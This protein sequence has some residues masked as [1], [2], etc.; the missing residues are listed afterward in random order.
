MTKNENIEDYKEVTEAEKMALEK[1]DAEW[2]EPPRS[3]VD[4]WNQACGVW[5]KYNDATGYFELNGLT[6]ISYR[7]ALDIYEFTQITS[8]NGYGRLGGIND[9]S[10]LNIRTNLPRVVSSHGNGNENE[11][12][13]FF[14]YYNESIEVLNIN[15]LFP[16]YSDERISPSSTTLKFICRCGKLQKVLGGISLFHSGENKEVKFIS[17]CQNLEYVEF[18]N[19]RNG[20]ILHL[21]TLPKLSYETFDYMIKNLWNVAVERPATCYVHE[22]I[23]KRFCDENDEQW[24]KLNQT[25]IS[26][27]LIFATQ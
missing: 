10:V 13:N 20:Q 25:A 9:K 11:N 21:Q 27:G 15:L 22:D 1:S 2:T 18:Y 7:Q 23:Y 19:V 12:W 3:F 5:G 24:Y 6:D 26:K 16:Q 8:V 14:C 4:L 17:D